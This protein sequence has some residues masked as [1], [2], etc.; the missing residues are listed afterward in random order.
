MDISYLG[1]NQR[2]FDISRK[3]TNAGIRTAN[4]SIPLVNQDQQTVIDKRYRKTWVM[5]RGVDRPGE[6]VTVTIRGDSIKNM[7]YLCGLISDHFPELEPIPSQ[8]SPS[9]IPFYKR[10]FKG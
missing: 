2:I 3:F 9:K 4:Y 6:D 10:Y 1:K 7:E 8:D 5:I